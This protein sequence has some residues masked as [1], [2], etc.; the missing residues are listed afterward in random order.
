MTVQ[1]KQVQ[2][3]L[4]Y[5]SDKVT[6]PAIYNYRPDPNDP[7]RSP[8]N[9][10]HNM[11]IA[12][13]R[14]YINELSLDREGLEIAN[15]SSNV[16]DYYDDEQVR[17]IYY[18]EIVKLVERA[19]GASH[20]HIFDYNVRCQSYAEQK[21]HGAQRPVRFVHNDYTVTSGPQR[22]RDLM[23]DEA[24]EL[25]TKRFAVINVWK[26]I[27][28]PVQKMPL[29]VCDASTMEQSDFVETALLYR[30]RQGEIY[31]VK[32]RPE[33]RWFYVSAMK[34]NEAMLLKCYDSE[35][36]G[37]ARFTA[38][39]AFEDPDSSADAPDRESIEVRT[40]AFF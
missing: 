35:N 15:I 40:L 17:S 29:A 23:G 19:T 6:N 33:H 14:N 38:Y 37:R 30:D 34:T 12:D 32:H 3:T 27:V 25:L 36:D 2:A 8:E 5:V 20:V 1:S 7:D 4:T 22:V 28:G 39:T 9:E 18:P 10:N 16:T 21:T 24:D 13:A 11:T 31:T 26:P